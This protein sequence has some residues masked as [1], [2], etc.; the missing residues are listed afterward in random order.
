M[1]KFRYNFHIDKIIAN[2]KNLAEELKDTFEPNAPKSGLT[3]N[4]DDR[5]Y[6]KELRA[7][8]KGL[9]GLPISIVLEEP[10]DFPNQGTF[11]A[12]E[13]AEDK[14]SEIIAAYLGTTFGGTQKHLPNYIEEESLK[15]RFVRCKL[16]SIEQID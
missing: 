7:Q 4:V 14:A 6:M 9:V 2:Q 1:S 12:K 5:E 16:V 8:I 15:G 13:R 3:L 11:F 10:K